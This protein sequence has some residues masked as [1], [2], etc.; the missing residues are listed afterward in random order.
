LLLSRAT[1]AA[2]RGDVTNC[3]FRAAAAVERWPR[4]EM[5]VNLTASGRGNMARCPDAVIQQME[6]VT[7]HRVDR[8]TRPRLPR[9]EVLYVQVAATAA[10]HG[11]RVL[12]CESADVS[13][14]GLRVSVSEPVLPCTP[15][16]VW[17]RLAELGCNFYLQ[18]RVRWYSESSGEVGIGMC[19]AEETDYWQWLALV[20]D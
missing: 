19:F 15:V 18:G 1:S 7:M 10:P 14:A 3:Q 5:D 8:R 6:D 11:A 4:T 12:R 20:D 2:G 16:E 13:S 17:I 9:R